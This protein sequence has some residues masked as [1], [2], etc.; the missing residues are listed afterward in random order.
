MTKFVTLMIIVA[1]RLIYH[2]SYEQAGTIPFATPSPLPSSATITQPPA[3]FISFKGG[4]SNNK[5]TL[6]W[7][8]KENET[9]GQFEVERSSDGKNFIMVALVFGTDKPETDNYLFYEKA[10]NKKV[11]Y[12][13]K[14]INKDHKIEYSSIIEIDPGKPEQSENTKTDSHVY[15]C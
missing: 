7:A 2:P 6:Q 4:L 12:R 13:I 11:L 10:G 9:A 8:V 15:Y 1:L 5:I 3:R 14:L